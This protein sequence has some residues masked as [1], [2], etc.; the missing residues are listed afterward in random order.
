[1]QKLKTS[2]PVVSMRAGRNDW[3]RIE[4]K[5]SLDR[6]EVYIYDEI[7]YFGV[8]ADDFVNDLNTVTASKIDL[9]LNTP[10]GE[11][12]DGI[13]IYNAL[14]N[15]EAEVTVYIDALA[16]SAGSFI[17]M[18][19]DTVIIEKTAQMMIHDAMSLA[20]GNAKDMREQADRLDNMSDTI[21][22][23][24]ADKT[25][26]SVEEWREKMSAETWFNA[27]EAVDAG[28]ADRINGQDKDD[29][30]TKKLE[31][32]W[33]LSIFAYAG[34]DKAPAPVANKT[35][36]EFDPSNFRAALKGVN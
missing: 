13:A 35:E 19:G 30:D 29:D 4:N 17:A 5:A 8:S 20:I 3:Y 26:G 21:A 12:F 34:R 22:G 7:G 1:M 32:S 36:L 10:G 33:D 27:Q 11:V 6:A 14:K 2:R 28:L 24:Y 15:H 16:A 23:I 18:A 9:H 25:A 31:N